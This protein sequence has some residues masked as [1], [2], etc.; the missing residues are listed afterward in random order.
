MKLDIRYV[1]GLFVGEG[2]FQTDK[3]QRSTCRSPSYQV[4]ARVA[5]RDRVLIFGLQETFDGSVRHIP[6]K[7]IEHADYYAWDVCGQNVIRFVDAVVEHLII[8]KTQAQL[9]RSFQR[10]KALNKNSPNSEARLEALECFY[11][12]MRILNRKGVSR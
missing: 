2:W 7:K 11:A 4:H 12:D 3:T 10:F 1:A 5:M 6:S 8:K 9:A